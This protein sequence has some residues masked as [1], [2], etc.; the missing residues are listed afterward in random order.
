M[1]D[2]RCSTFKTYSPPLQDSL[3]Q[4]AEFHTKFRDSGLQNFNI[5]LIYKKGCAK[6]NHPSRFGDSLVL[7]SK[8]RSAINIDMAAKRRKKHKNQISGLIISMGYETEIQE[9]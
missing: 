5:G 3:F 6:R 4:Q 8:K 9:F 2:V 1:L 7:D